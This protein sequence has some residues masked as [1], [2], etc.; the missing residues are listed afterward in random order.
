VAL[1]QDCDDFLRKPFRETDLFEMLCKHLG[2]RFV[3]EEGEWQKAKSEGQGD[4]DVLT[5][6]ALAGLPQKLLADLEYAVTTTDITKIV[7]LLAE[8]QQHDPALAN[9]LRKLVEQ[10]DYIKILTILQKAVY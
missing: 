10:F 7:A 1:T 4:Q 2:V 9:A 5:L 6:T 3:Y 8:I